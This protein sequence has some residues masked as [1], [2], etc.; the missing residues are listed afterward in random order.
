MNNPFNI[1]GNHNPKDCVFLV[2]LNGQYKWVV[3]ALKKIIKYFSKCFVFPN[4]FYI[5]ALN[6]NKNKK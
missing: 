2:I 4:L 6:P 5:F 1:I 3:L